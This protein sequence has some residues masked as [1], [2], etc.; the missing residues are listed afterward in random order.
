MLARCAISATRYGPATQSAVVAVIVLSLALGI[1]ANGDFS[2][3]N[4]VL[5]KSLRSSRGR[6]RRGDIDGGEGFRAWPASNCGRRPPSY[7]MLSVSNDD[8]RNDHSSTP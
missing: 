5:L 8:V 4:A 7:P 6:P 3:V 1:G 2:V